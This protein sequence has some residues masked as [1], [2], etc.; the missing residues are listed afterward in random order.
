MVLNVTFPRFYVQMVEVFLRHKLQT[1]TLDILIGLLSS[2]C[3]ESLSPESLL[4]D[5]AITPLKANQFFW[6]D[7]EL[8]VDVGS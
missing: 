6:L 7:L 4:G 3:K 2:L 5:P 1:I 8:E